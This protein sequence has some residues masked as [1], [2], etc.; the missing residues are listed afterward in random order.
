MNDSTLNSAD[1]V[2]LPQPTAL[3][4]ALETFPIKLASYR[5]AQTAE[6]FS[7]TREELAALLTHTGIYD[8]SWRDFLRCSGRDRVRWL[9]GMVTNSVKDLE[10]NSGCYA[11]VL[12]AQGRIQGDLNIYRRV[13]DPEALW[14]Q[15]D[16]EQREPLTTFVRRY[17]IMDQ[18]T[19]NPVE[20]WTALGI[21]GPQA[22]KTL[23]DLGFSVPEPDHLTEST[24]QGRTVVVAAA[25]GPLVPGYQLWIESSAVLDLWNALT[26]ADATPCGSTAVDQLRILEGTPAYGI[27]IADR[28]LPQETSQ[29][30]ALNFNKGCYLGQEIVE[31]IRSRGNVHRTLSGF[32]LEGNLPQPKTPILAGEKSVG[33]LT[34]IARIYIPGAGEKNVALGIIR[35]EVLESNELLT[36]DGNKVIPHALPFDFDFATVQP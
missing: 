7:S 11:F 3:A 1:R 33:E 14:L 9:N 34:S 29:M 6:V 21:A 36:V 26:G 22:S 23:G 30:R 4:S 24:W 12:N 35:R 15:M 32:V 16:H 10:E 31:R 5:G 20:Q 8:L 28:D 19:L 17:I 2:T 18:V 25:H 13:S 27:D